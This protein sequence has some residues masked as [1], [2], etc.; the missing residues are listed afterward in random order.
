MPVDGGPGVWDDR[1]GLPG[2]GRY[3]GIFRQRL[4]ILPIFVRPA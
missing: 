4:S 2:R 1:E 3:T